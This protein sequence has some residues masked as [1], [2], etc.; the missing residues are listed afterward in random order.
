VKRCGRKNASHMR[1]DQKKMPY[2]LTVSQF[3]ER[4]GWTG[5]DRRLRCQNG[6]ENLIADEALAHLTCMSTALGC[7][8]EM[9]CEAEADTSCGVGWEASL[10]IICCWQHL[11]VF[12]PVMPIHPMRCRYTYLR[13]A[14][15]ASRSLTSSL[16]HQRWDP[17]VAVRFGSAHAV[18][19]VHSI[20]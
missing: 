15:H 14:Q 17:E 13:A 19:H 11:L 4:Q 16:V 6:P 9:W 12:A 8:L 5:E 3:A 1:P 10:Y 20:L 2:L 18:V 7:I